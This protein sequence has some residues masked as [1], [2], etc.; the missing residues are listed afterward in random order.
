MDVSMQ[1]IWLIVAV[2]FGILELITTSLVSIWFVFGAVVAM[3]V[4][5]FNAPVLFQVIVFIIISV[6]SL[7]FTRPLAKK[8]LN[9]KIV[10]TNIDSLVG[11]TLIAKTDID[12][13]KMSGKADLDG[14]TWIV[15]SEDDSLISA[16]EE[17]EVVKIEGAKLIVR[18]IGG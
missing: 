14:T 10:K 17:I 16:G 11:R 6:V 15:V 13:L 5:L 7:L 3:I 4:A 8:Y 1:I 2:V 18:R 9:D 12:N